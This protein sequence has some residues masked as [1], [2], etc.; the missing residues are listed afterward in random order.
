MNCELELI[1]KYLKREFPYVVKIKEFNVGKVTSEIF[2]MSASTSS[3][4]GRPIHSITIC[5]KES[6]F[7]QLENNS[8]LKETIFSSF[9][10][11]CSI[12]ITHVCPEIEIISDDYGTNLAVTLIS[13][14]TS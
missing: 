14:K 11:E 5:I 3:N 8:L 4:F 10:K 1:E 13:E 7:N 9:S 6:F 12:I 2:T